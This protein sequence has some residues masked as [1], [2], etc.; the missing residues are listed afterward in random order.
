M[1]H[2][3]SSSGHITILMLDLLRGVALFVMK[4]QHENI[5]ADM[6][7]CRK[8]QNLF[9]SIAEEIL[10]LGPVSSQSLRLQL[11]LILLISNA[12]CREIPGLIIVT[13]L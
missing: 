2:I 8:A 6:D 5:N 3:P 9:V 13:K 1:G 7:V 4:T 12:S 11:S 10:L